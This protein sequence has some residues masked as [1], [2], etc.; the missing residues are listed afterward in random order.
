MF[1][2]EKRGMRQ[3]LDFL[4]ELI[5]EFVFFG[6]VGW[7]YE[8]VLTSISWG[9]FADRGWLH[10]P[11]LPIYG[12]CGLAI[13]LVLHKVKSVPLIFVFGTLFTTAAELASSYIIELFT[14]KRL[15]D[16]DSWAFNFQGR[17]SL[18]SSLIFGVLCVLLIKVLHP[19]AGYV[20]H[21]I[22]DRA[23]R[24]SAVI[25]LAAIAADIVITLAGF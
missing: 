15:W 5:I 24:I 10:L 21:K 6:F 17:I 14:D 22:G 9:R 25:F 7:T 13:L 11:I 19:F 23:V 4:S 2:E 20:M 18:V 8:T 1:Q 16:Y 3:K 12:F